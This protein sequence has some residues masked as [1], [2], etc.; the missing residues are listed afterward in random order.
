MQQ[1][2]AEKGVFLSSVCFKIVIVQ[3]QARPC[4]D[5][6][7]TLPYFLLLHIIV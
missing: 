7:G 4:G 3:S 6:R 2:Q 1:V 5:E